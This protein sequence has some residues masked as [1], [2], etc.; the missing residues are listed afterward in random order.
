MSL[1]YLF[2]SGVGAPDGTASSPAGGPAG[3]IYPCL[4]PPLSL[5]PPLWI[6]FL[7]SSA[8]PPERRCPALPS[9]PA[10][11]LY[12][13]PA[14]L[15]LL[16]LLPHLA[17]FWLQDFVPSLSPSRLL[18]PGCRSSWWRTTRRRVRGRAEQE[19]AGERIGPALGREAWTEEED[20]LASTSSPLAPLKRR[21]ALPP[22][23][24]LPVLRMVR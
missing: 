15:L 8:P 10:D 16:L 18:H 23:S 14:P 5:F 21:P 24:W 2:S 4:P 7:P 19:A 17:P 9:P 6:P 20:K 11:L 1:G 13:P 3:R 22:F 12:F